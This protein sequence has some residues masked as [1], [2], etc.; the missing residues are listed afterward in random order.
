LFRSIRNYNS[1]L[2]RQFG[3]IFLDDPVRRFQLA[4]ITIVVLIS[5]ATV[6]YVLIEGMTL[7]DALYMTVITITTVGFGEVAPLS[8]T[9]RLFTIIVILLGVTALTNAASS[10]IGIL[11]GPNLWHAMRKRRMKFMLENIKDHYIVCGYGRMGRQ[12]TVDLN[13]RGESYVL[14]DISK[15]LEPVLLENRILYVIG[16]A[17]RDEVLIEAG[18]HSARGLVAALDDD[19]DNVMTVLTAREMN[20]DLFIVARVVNNEAERKLLRAGADRVVNPYQIGGNRIAVALIRPAV[21]DFMDN[22][23]HFNRDIDVEMG[24]LY[25]GEGTILAGQTIATTGL[26]QSHR[27]NILA[28]QRSNSKIIITPDISLPIETG[29]T[30][31]I[32]G[33]PDR[34]RDLERIYPGTFTEK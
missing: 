22:I 21:N 23:S 7:A 11:M 4:L 12:V 3:D 2:R 26:R 29:D 34:V 1:R 9:G 19:P 18:I 20:P 8:E 17:T 6:G 5:T 14:I 13:K 24:E 31:I 15:Q 27:V 32:I 30:L 28:L 33:P 10:L 16:D 25:I